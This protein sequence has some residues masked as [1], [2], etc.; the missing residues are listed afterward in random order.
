MS[1]AKPPHTITLHAS[2]WETHMQG[3]SVHLLCVTQRERWLEPKASNVGLSRPWR[4]RESTMKAWFTQSPLN[5]WCWHVSVTWTLWN[6]YLGCNMKCSYSN[7]FILCSRGNSGSSFPVAVL[8][9]ASFN[10]VL[11]GFATALEETLKVL[12]IVCIDCSC[13]N[14]GLGILPNRAI[15]CIPLYLITTQ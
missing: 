15:F 5:S 9:R 4:L 1:P 3:S 14:D 6:I 10:I 12:E 8:M 11:D 2:R 7:E 13:H